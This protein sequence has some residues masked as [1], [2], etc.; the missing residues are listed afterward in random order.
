MPKIDICRC[1]HSQ[2]MHHNGFSGPCGQV[3][4]SMLGPAFCSCEDFVEDN[5][6]YLERLVDEQE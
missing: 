3:L 6:R 2:L 1:G 5:L 4:I